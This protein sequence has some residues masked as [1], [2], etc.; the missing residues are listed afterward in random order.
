VLGT[1]I[2][3]ESFWIDETFSGAK[4]ALPT[5][6]EWA[7][8]MHA[9]S[10]SDLQMPLYMIFLWCWQKIGGSN[11]FW[12]RLGNAPWFLL[13]FVPFCRERLA[14]AVVAAS[15]GFIWYYLNEARPYAMQVGAT[16]LIIAGGREYFGDE[17]IPK[18]LLRSRA[19]L[20]LGIVLLSVSSLLGMIWAGA[21]VFAIGMA[22]PL[23]RLSSEF[24]AKP[25]LWSIT[26]AVLTIIAGYYLW[27][28]TEGARATA[29][30][31]TDFRN[32][33][34][35]CYELLGFS[36]LGPGRLEIRYEGFAA[37]AR[38]AWP[39]ALHI[40]L[41]IAVGVAGVRALAHATPKRLLV[42]VSVSVA[43]ASVFLLLVGYKTHFRVLG[44]HLTP[45]I[46]LWLIIAAA[47]VE[48]LCRR[49]GIGR[50]LAVAFLVLSTISGL[51]LRFA[52]RHARDDYR[53]AAALA[54]SGVTAG[55]T[56]WWNADPIGAAY[57]GVVASDRVALVVNQSAADLR[58]LPEP[59]LVIASKPEIYD[60]AGALA[61]YLRDR[62]YR[63]VSILP[64]FTIWEITR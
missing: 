53:G 8:A 54:K 28:L 32:L 61:Q 44:R 43:A 33:P 52:A 13:G 22:A 26:G 49:G 35:A 59:E 30:G 56:I 39:L 18:R 50:V 2:S 27:T 6:A 46:A 23:S 24:R 63:R 21:A 20:A 19:A 48:A 62:Q 58:A 1:A 12:L 31:A 16:L 47:G 41:V 17:T 25:G 5:F 10:G 38:F 51:E 34:Y 14:L 11:E 9:W 7:T 60:N 42:A 55:K 64:A 45:T 4:A 40:V 3:N 37:L 15:N 29:I 57:Y 36:G